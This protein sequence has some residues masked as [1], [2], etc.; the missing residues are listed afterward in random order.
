MNR[1]VKIKF[2][3]KLFPAWLHYVDENYR[4]SEDKIKSENAKSV[5]L[6]KMVFLDH[7]DVLIP[8]DD[9][10]FVMEQKAAYLTPTQ[11]VVFLVYEGGNFM[12]LLPEMEIVEE[13][14]SEFFPIEKGF[15]IICENDPFDKWG[16]GLDHIFKGMCQHNSVSGFHYMFSFRNRTEDEIIA[17]FKDAPAILF[18][19]SYTE[20]DWFELMLRC[21]IKS[22]TEAKVIGSKPHYQDTL[23]RYN[24]FVA[25]A[26][27]FGINVITL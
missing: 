18:N 16:G 8:L 7:G 27:K 19:S 5:E 17:A 22:K 14:Q 25:M 10:S 13:V 11:G 1:Y 21:I 20:V 3:G 2:N 9:V 23:D 15:A 26:E 24:K 12:A 4:W 6:A